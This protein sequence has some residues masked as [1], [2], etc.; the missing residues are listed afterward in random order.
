MQIG[1][2]RAECTERSSFQHSIVERFLDVITH[3]VQWSQHSTCPIE[4]VCTVSRV[5]LHCF[6]VPKESAQQIPRC[7]MSKY[8]PV[9]RRHGDGV[10]YGFPVTGLLGVVRRHRP[11]HMRTL[12][13][14]RFEQSKAG[15]QQKSRAAVRRYC[16]LPTRKKLRIL[17]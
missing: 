15:M 2:D 3:A 9:L 17:S 14:I 12:F 13:L 5:L 16:S 7:H 4:P 1:F 8:T 11:C 10:P 6:A